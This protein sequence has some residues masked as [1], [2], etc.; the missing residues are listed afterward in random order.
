[1]FLLNF[2]A[3]VLEPEE[4]KFSTPQELELLW[5]AA[6]GQRPQNLDGTFKLRLTK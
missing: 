6:N 2:P 4:V 1:M 3:G 5:D